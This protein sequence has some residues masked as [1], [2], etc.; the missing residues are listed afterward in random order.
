MGAYN[1]GVLIFIFVFY[2]M[3]IVWLQ[4][5]KDTG[6]SR[7]LYSRFSASSQGFSY[8]WEKMSHVY[9]LLTNNA[10]GRP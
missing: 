7:P 1:C 9:T 4:S 6:D 10:P 8:M 2:L 3:S 5:E